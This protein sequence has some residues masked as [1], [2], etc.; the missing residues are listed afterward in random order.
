MNSPKAFFSAVAQGVSPLYAV[1]LSLLSV[2]LI[3]LVLLIARELKRPK[4][5]RETNPQILRR[6]APPLEATN[7][8]LRTEAKGIEAEG[9]HEQH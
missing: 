1:F 4:R 2:A 3:A 5:S 8:Q 6:L 9:A 7:S